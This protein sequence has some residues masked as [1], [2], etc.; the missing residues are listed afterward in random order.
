VA[1]ASHFDCD[2]C[3]SV[4]HRLGDTFELGAERGNVARHGF[5][6]LGGTKPSGLVV[7]VGAI[8]STVEGVT[9]LSELTLEPLEGD[10]HRLSERRPVGRR[11]LTQLGNLIKHLPEHSSSGAFSWI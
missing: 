11:G 4:G 8:G 10:G 2:L 6:L 5:A 9:Q 1:K 3:C 7:A